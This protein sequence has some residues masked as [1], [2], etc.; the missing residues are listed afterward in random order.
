MKLGLYIASHHNAVF[1]RLALLHVWLQTQQP[2]VLAVHENGHTLSFQPLVEDVVK[3]LQEKGTQVD[4]T[5]TPRRLR[6]P[7]YHLPLLKTLLERGCD[8]FIKFDHDDLFYRNH[9]ETLLAEVEGYDAAVSG[10]A[11]VLIQPSDDYGLVKHNVLFGQ[12]NPTGGMSDAVIFN[13][14]VAEQYCQDL[15]TAAALSLDHSSED[16]LILGNVTL[17]RFR[18]HRFYTKPTACYVSH[19]ANL[20]TSHWVRDEKERRQKVQ[21]EVNV[22]YGVIRTIE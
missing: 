21:N 22:G 18:V 10:L 5:H 4:W 9:I 6:H 20:S 8:W 17:P 7:H 11:T 15:E 14:V 13:R 1:L 19:G 2:D 16:D 3:A 12:F